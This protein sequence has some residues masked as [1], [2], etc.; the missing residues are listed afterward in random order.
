MKEYMYRLPERTGDPNDAI[1]SGEVFWV[2]DMNP[3]WGERT[4]W[5]YER[6][7]LFAF[8]NRLIVPNT[9]AAAVVAPAMRASAEPVAEPPPQTP[10]QTQEA[11]PRTDTDGP[12]KPEQQEAFPRN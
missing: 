7:K 1:V 10:P 11:F 2:Q 4:P 6:V 9:K 12:P 3:R 5:K 8:A